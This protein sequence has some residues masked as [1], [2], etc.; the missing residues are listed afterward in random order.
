MKKF[1]KFV[2]AVVESVIEGREKA[3][4]ARRYPFGL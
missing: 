4:R 1:W 3:A 2:R